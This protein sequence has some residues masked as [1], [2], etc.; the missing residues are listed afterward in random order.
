MCATVSDQSFN[1]DLGMTIAVTLNSPITLPCGAVLKNRLVKAAMT[2]GAADTNNRATQRHVRLYRRWAGSGAGMLLT[3][4]VQV[5]R[6]FLERPGNVA[7]D[8]PQSP[9]ALAALR[10]YAAA[11]TQN[12]THLWMQISHAGRQTPASVNPEPGA[13]GHRSGYAWGAV[14]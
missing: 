4:N 3:G 14:R 11:G 6:R 2:E 5:D 8:G 10:A 7:I 1:R 9:E 13:V 12:G